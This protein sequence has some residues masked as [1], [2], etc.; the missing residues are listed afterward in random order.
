MDPEVWLEVQTELRLEQTSARLPGY[1]PKGDRRTE[2]RIVN[3]KARTLPSEL[4]LRVV[5]DILRV[6]ANLEVLRFRNSECLAQICIETVT[7]QTDDCVL[8]QGSPLTGQWIL[9][10]N[11]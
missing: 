9:E 4:R 8:T 3:R 5:Q 6:E 7:A 11:H 2:S 1:L 10:R